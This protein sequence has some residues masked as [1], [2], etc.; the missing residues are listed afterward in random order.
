MES[1]YHMRI[2][3]RQ[4]VPTKIF[5]DAPVHV[6]SVRLVELIPTA[7]ASLTA[8]PSNLWFIQPS[9]FIFKA[10]GMKIHGM[11]CS[12]QVTCAYR[13]NK[14]N[15]G[16][17]FFHP[18]KNTDEKEWEVTH[19]LGICGMN[20]LSEVTTLP[21]LAA[22]KKSGDRGDVIFSICCGSSCLI[23]W[24]E[25]YAILRERVFQVSHGESPPC[26]VLFP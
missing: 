21:S 17:S 13:N 26:L 25:G 6:F 22:T 2:D 24:S 18:S 12:V 1:F 15:I 11:P 19:D 16:K 9:L 23:T 4:K 14:W 7:L 10:Y 3:K 20:L 8:C 5:V